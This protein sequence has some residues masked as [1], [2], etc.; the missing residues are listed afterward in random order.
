[1]CVFLVL[2]AH[3]TGM[4]L[5]THLLTDVQ[6]VTHQV[7]YKGNLLAYQEFINKKV[8]GVC[9]DYLIFFRLVIKEPRGFKIV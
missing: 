4:E 6:R 1:M 5:C 7:H 2:D 8:K 3:F 9:K